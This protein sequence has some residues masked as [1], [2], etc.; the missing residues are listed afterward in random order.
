[1]T[2]EKF[3]KS[4]HI[5]WSPDQRSSVFWDMVYKNVIYNQA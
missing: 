4:I 5:I 2:V 3:W 1:M